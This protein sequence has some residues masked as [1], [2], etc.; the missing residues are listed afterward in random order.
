ML[1]LNFFF[2]QTVRKANLLPITERCLVSLVV[3]Y[4]RLLQLSVLLQLPVLWV[5]R[6]YPRLSLLSDSL[7]RLL[8]VHHWF[9]DSLHHRLLMLMSQRC[10]L[11]CLLRCRPGFIP[12]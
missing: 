2:F 3:I 12:I 4:T 7:G 10:L 6:L 1:I 8:L 5:W 9:L 11:L